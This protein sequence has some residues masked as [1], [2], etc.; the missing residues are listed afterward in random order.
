MI[1]SR[2]SRT[3]PHHD[4]LIQMA[5][6]MSTLQLMVGQRALYLTAIRKVNLGKLVFGDTVYLSC[7][8]SDYSHQAYLP[9]YRD[10]EFHRTSSSSSVMKD[11]GTVTIR[12]PSVRVARATLVDSTG[13]SRRSERNVHNQA[14]H[15][16][17]YCTG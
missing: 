15:L 11:L 14:T 5:L 16:G 17:T 2:T 7:S 12:G 3:C 13:S 1:N 8:D 9:Q 10:P 6:G 4:L